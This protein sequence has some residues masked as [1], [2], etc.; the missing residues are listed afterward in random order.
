MA[1]NIDEKINRFF[2]KRSATASFDLLCE[3]VEKV[4]TDPLTEQDDE[5]IR[6][7][8]PTIKITED[9]GKPG[10][11]DRQIIEEF[12]KKIEGDTIEAKIA[13]L[14]SIVGGEGTPTIGAILSTL[15]VIEVLNAILAEFTESAGGFIF[16]G[17][18]AGLFGGQSVQ[19]TDV[20]QQ[21]GESGAAGKPITD[22]VL[23]G[24]QYSLKLLGK[25]TGVKGSFRNMVEHFK[26]E[27]HVVY[28]DARRT[29]TGLEFGEFTITLN[30]FLEVFQDPFA[31]I[32]TKIIPDLSA[33][34]LKNQISR[35]LQSKQA[36]KGIQFA[37]KGFIP[38]ETSRTFHFSPAQAE[39]SEKQLRGRG[40][41][42]EAFDELL[43]RILDA[44][45][46]ELEQ[47]G[48]FKLSFA[49]AKFGSKSEAL[50]GS[51][52]YAERVQTAIKQYTE[53]P[54]EQ[55]KLLLLQLLEDTP[56]YLGRQQ[57]EFTRNQAESIA[58]FRKVGELGIGEQTLKTA[59]LNYAE[60]LN[61]TIKPVYGAM[62]SFRKNINSYFLG[63][64]TKEKDR[65]T[66]GTDA[67]NDA[68][69]LG[70]A[71]DEAVKAVEKAEK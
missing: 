13:S 61:Q 59:W 44:P 22:V 6:E 60:L 66:F 47:F 51:F 54:S 43:Q 7:L 38:G 40:L 46:K 24:K 57:F 2:T 56:G 31:A 50:F 11:K 64:S 52:S 14:N 71:T 5:A 41:S 10:S 18:L 30:N 55:T 26:V 70:T 28:L 15:V 23:G 42:P 33:R 45:N 12:T 3:F 4:M 63:T 19:I 62:N 58:G 17:F 36:I 39:I 53:N 27:D 9:W 21:E 65:K 1:K 34:K 35:I 32:K 8:L 68:Q 29:G 49:E 67:I 69:N 16:E 25:S 37:S 48:P 20:G